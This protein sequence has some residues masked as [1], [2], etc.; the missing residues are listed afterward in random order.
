M[1][2]VHAAAVGLAQVEAL[3][4]HDLFDD[5]GMKMVQVLSVSGFVRKYVS[6]WVRK[7]LLSR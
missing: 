1:G 5:V 2:N 6:N 3:V 7:V 4:V